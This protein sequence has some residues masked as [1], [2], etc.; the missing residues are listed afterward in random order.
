MAYSSSSDDDMEAVEEQIPPE[1]PQPTAGEAPEQD[2]VD[3]TVEELTAGQDTRAGK[4]I[5]ELNEVEEV[6]RLAAGSHG[7]LR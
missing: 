4:R 5:A 2:E 6:S 7:T 1:L 3:E